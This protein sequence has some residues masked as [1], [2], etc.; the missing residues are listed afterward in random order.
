ME[1]ARDGE[2]ALMFEPDDPDALAGAVAR[3]AGDQAL[4]QRL[5]QALRERVRRDFSAELMAARYLAVYRN[6]IADK[7]G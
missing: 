5:G 4:R 2:S 1:I 3:M 7:S 6:A